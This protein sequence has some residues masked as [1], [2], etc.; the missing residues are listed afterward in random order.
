MLKNIFYISFVISLIVI[1]EN[2]VVQQ[3]KTIFII[4]DVG[5]SMFAFLCIVVWIF[6]WFWLTWFTKKDDDEI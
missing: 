6:V 5:P 1:I 2:M 3:W 4:K